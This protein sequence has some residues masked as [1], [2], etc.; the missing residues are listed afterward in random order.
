VRTKLVTHTKHSSLPTL[1]EKLLALPHPPPDTQR[2]AT[3]TAARWGV[4]HRHQAGVVDGRDQHSAGQTDGFVDVVVLFLI[5]VGVEVV[6]LFE[7]DDDVGS[8]G[9]SSDIRPW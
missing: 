4:R 5:P 2:A 6:G 3:K 1:S 7:G 9:Q 8:G